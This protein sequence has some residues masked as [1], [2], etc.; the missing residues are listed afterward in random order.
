MRVKENSRHK[1]FNLDSDVILLIEQGANLNNTT[2][3]EFLEFLVNS[4]DENLNPVKK[5]KHLQ[6]QKKKL[7]EDISEIENTEETITSNLEKIEEF[8]KMKQEKK[9]EVIDNLSRVLAEKRIDDA[10]IIAKNQSVRLGV[11]ATQLIFEAMEKLK[12]GGI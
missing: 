8:R 6:I 1:T 9:P 4:W 7:R 11:P 5:L 10:E 3:S 12:R 2:Q